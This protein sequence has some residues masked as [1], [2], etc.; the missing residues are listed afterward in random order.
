MKYLMFSGRKMLVIHA[1]Q[2]SVKF[3]LH[4]SGNMAILPPESTPDAELMSGNGPLVP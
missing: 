2:G 3:A 4:D 1:V